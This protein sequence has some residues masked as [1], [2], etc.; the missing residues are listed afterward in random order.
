[1]VHAHVKGRII[2]SG[3]LVINDKKEILLLYR[4]DHH[5]YETPGGK[6]RLR[7]CN[8]PDDPSF[9]DLAKTAERELYEELGNNIKVKELKY[10]GNV[11]FDIPGGKLAIANKFI[12]SI[13]S[14]E[15]RLN[16]PERFSRF[17]YLPIEHLENYPIS[18]DLKLL[19]TKLKEYVEDN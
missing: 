9:E 6:V 5:H 4:T 18:P 10:F 14:G 1:M 8:H 16:E 15:P 12:T 7:E 19:I 17:D 13:I 11:A 3:C 2:L